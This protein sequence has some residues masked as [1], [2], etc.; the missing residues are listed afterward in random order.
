MKKQNLLLLLSIFAIL[1]ACTTR[2]TPYKEIAISISE[3]EKTAS[4]SYND[5]SFFT[6][7]KAIKPEMTDNSIIGEISQIEMTDSLIYIL[8]KKSNALRVFATTGKYLH[9]I[10]K[11]GD[12]PDEYLAVNAFYINPYNRTINLFDPLKNAVN[13]YDF[14]GNFIETVKH[15]NRHFAAIARATPLNDGTLFCF[16]NPNF[17]EEASGYFILNEADYSLNKHIYKY[18][19]KIEKQIAYHSL[20]EHPFCKYNDEIH[21]VTLFSNLVQTFSDSEIK[22]RYYLDNNKSAITDEYLQAIATETE[23]NYFEMLKK[24]IKGNT[25]AAGCKSIFETDRYIYIDFYDNDLFTTTLLWDKKE[26]HGYYIED[27]LQYTPDFGSISYY[28]NN[29]LVKIWKDRDIIFLKEK[30]KKEPSLRE[31]YHT[32]ILHIIDNYDEE[33]NPVLLLY[34][35]KE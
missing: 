14:S 33:D 25:Y 19:V 15:D 9:S 28:H 1:S 2:K 23:I 4:I 7:C 18:P 31:K 17:N 20:V 3:M 16:T 8:D 22:P 12:G 11:K 35:T 34:T 10:G 27:Y 26:K 29:T 24:T 30:T 21:F 6:E 5:R 32:D 13:R